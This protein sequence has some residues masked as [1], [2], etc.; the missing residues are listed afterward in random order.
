MCSHGNV[1]VTW[2]CCNKYHRLGGLNHRCSFL[3]IPKSRCLA[4]QCLVRNLFLACKLPISCYVLSC[5]FLYKVANSIHE[6]YKLMPSLPPKVPTSK[7]LD[8]GGQSFNLRILGITQTSSPWRTLFASFVAFVSF[9]VIDFGSDHWLHTCGQCVHAVLYGAVW[10]TELTHRR[11]S[12]N[13][14]WVKAGKQRKGAGIWSDWGQ[15]YL[16]QSWRVYQSP[17]AGSN[18]LPCIQWLAATYIYG[19]YSSGGKQ[20]EMD[21]IVQR[22]RCQQY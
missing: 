20:S 19:L 13:M 10:S 9:A 2:G 4:F 15:W 7:H 17:N 1:L 16:E 22:S 3:I 21:L 6:S 11:W 5:V 18:N 12:V 14:P 8:I